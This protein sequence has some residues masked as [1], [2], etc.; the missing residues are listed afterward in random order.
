M[1]LYDEIDIA[2]FTWSLEERTFYYP[3]PCGDRFFI[4]VDEML[5]G[6]DIAGC[7]SCSLRIRILFDEASLD[8]AMKT[9]APPSGDNAS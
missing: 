9:N 3:C 5:D 6:E 2:D 8:I 1:S 7:P 4:R